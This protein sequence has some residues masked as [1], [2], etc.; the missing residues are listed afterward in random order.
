MTGPNGSGKSTLARL[1]AGLLEPSRGQITV[2]GLELAQVSLEWWRGQII[3]LPQEPGFIPGSVRTNIMAASP[4]LDSEGLNR[5]L[6][7][8][9]LRKFLDVHPEG[10]DLEIA[11]DGR[12]LPQGIRR[13]LALARAMT[14]SGN[15]VFL[16]E[17][18]EALDLEGWKMIKNNIRLFKE[19]NKTIF[20]FSSDPRLFLDAGIMVDLGQK[21]VPSVTTAGKA[22]KQPEN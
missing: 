14:T 19:Q 5:V 10:L 11:E 17:P 16:D 7:A 21:P 13:R 18:A 12:P 9:D 15:M 4:G 22:G 6:S 20:I 1:M 3:Y 2:D 8:T